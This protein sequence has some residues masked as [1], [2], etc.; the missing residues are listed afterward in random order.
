MVV[1]K[2]FLKNAAIVVIAAVRVGGRTQGNSI[3]LNPFTDQ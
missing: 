3:I 2:I 1:R